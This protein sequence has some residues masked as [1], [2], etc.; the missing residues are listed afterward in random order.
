MAILI[1]AVA[2]LMVIG[3]VRGALL[4]VRRREGK[5]TVME[6]ES[7]CREAARAQQL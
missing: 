7:I 5:E 4:L 1:T 2:L 3:V 6:A